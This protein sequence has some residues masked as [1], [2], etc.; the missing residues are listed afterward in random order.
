MLPAPIRHT[1]RPLLFFNL[2]RLLLVGLLS[3]LALTDKLPAPLGSYHF[4]LFLAA[5]LLY[6]GIS[7]VWFFFIW[8][9]FPSFNTQATAQVFLD[10]LLLSLLMYSSGG[11][12]SG[13]GMLVLVAIAGGSLL[14]PGRMAILFAAMG[15][16]ALLAEQ[17]RWSLVD[18]LPVAN[19][20]QAGMLGI[21]F[22]ATAAVAFELGAR[23][24][25]SAA[26]VDQKN[27]DLADLGLLNEEIIQRLQSGLL[28]ADAENRV[29]LANRSAS[30]LLQ[31]PIAKGD[32]IETLS[33][34]LLQPLA[35][36]RREGQS[37]GVLAVHGGDPRNGVL[38]R[39]TNL[40]KAKSAHTLIV[41]EDASV[42]KQQAQLLK[43]ASLGKLSASIAHEVRNPLGAISHAAQLL[44]EQGN[45]PAEI[46]QLTSIIQ[47]HSRRVN[48]LVEDIL[49]LG[50]NKEFH[51]QSFLLAPWVKQFIDDFVSTREVPPANLRSAIPMQFQMFFDR[52]QLQQVLWNLCDNALLHGGQS[53]QETSIDI[54]ARLDAENGRQLLEV[55]DRGPGVAPTMLERIFEPFFTTAGRGTGLGLYVCR[56][57]C[58][59]NR[60]TLEYAPRQG[61]GSVFC[62]SM[63]LSEMSQVV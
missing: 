5:S 24:R 60:A 37:G 55:A 28:V 26:L 35:N 56:E 61:G 18:D 40:G 20:T 42:L 62:I 22:F 34:S 25:R 41:L 46:R 17:I 33:P 23:A 63:P 49:E 16:I 10:I 1:W 39:F 47:R 52:D 32:A 58:E 59:N 12:G 57:L 36:W 4:P 21:A 3:G 15:S 54:T 7:L 38:A 43:M 27:R 44:D 8:W 2:Y 13:L 50:S 14:M 6:C 51:P 48:R 53:P 19:Y 9:R 45:D 29:V 11:I 30:A 31:V